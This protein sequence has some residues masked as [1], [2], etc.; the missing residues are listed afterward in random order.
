MRRC[1]RC[2]ETK[3]LTDFYK[4]RTTRKWTCKRCTNA[5]GVERAR[6][7]PERGRERLARWRAANP[8][9]EA[10]NRRA[11]RAKNRERRNAS[12][13]AAYQ[14]NKER[15][16]EKRKAKSEETKARCKRWYETNKAYALAQ[17]R[18]W[19]ANNRD[20]RRA[21][22]ARWT[23]AHPEYNRAK[24]R[25]RRAQKRA[26]GFERN[27]DY[28]AIFSRHNGRCGICDLPVAWDAVT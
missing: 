6:Q 19:V 3:P 26:D 15:L 5:V 23:K 24:V 25:N 7:H 21:I 4:D 18:A 17:S 8:G 13:R 1:K 2:S 28:R 16:R 11:W 22:V 9:R 14:R 27:V 12:E 20:R 10:L